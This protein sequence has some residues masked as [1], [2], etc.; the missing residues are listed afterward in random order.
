[1][2]SDCKHYFSSRFSGGTIAG[3]VVGAFLILVLVGIVGFL[4]YRRHQSQPSFS[5]G[6]VVT[7]KQ[8]EFQIY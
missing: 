1:M 6:T 3:G 7:G 5:S 8:M 2:E 4:C